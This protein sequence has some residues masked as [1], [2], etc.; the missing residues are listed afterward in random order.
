MS[1]YAVFIYELEYP[2]GILYGLYN[3]KE[4][5]ITEILKYNKNGTFIRTNNINE[6]QYTMNI[7]IQNEEDYFVEAIIR[8]L[9]LNDTL[10]FLH[11]PIINNSIIQ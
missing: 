2:S 8:K 1:V 11:G 6:E 4:Q 9:T 3:T 7:K 5:A 10:K